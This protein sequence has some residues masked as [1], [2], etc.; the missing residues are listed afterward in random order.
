[1][2][3]LQFVDRIRRQ[4]SW[5]TLVAN[6]VYTADADATWLDSW[7]A[8]VVCI[9]HYCSAYMQLIQCFITLSVRVRWPRSYPF[10]RPRSLTF[11]S[12]NNSNELYGSGTA[13]CESESANRSAANVKLWTC[14]CR[15]AA[16]P[17]AFTVDVHSWRFA[18]CYICY[19]HILN[20]WRHLEN[21][22]MSMN[23]CAK[24]QSD[25][26]W[27]GLFTASHSNNNNNKTNK[28]VGD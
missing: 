24:F 5:A 12:T 15:P 14:Y 21:P 16:G 19:M 7:V 25:Q 22:T 6:S 8:S 9:G 23:N 18:V 3:S 17:P 28:P 1:M 20:S 26:I 2:F 27:H 10:W 11:T 4:S 13:A